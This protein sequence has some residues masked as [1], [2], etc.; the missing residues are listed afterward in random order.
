MATKKK[1][2]GRGKGKP[3]PKGVGGGGKGR[4]KI[5]EDIKQAFKE[6]SWG[7]I[8]ALTDVLYDDEQ[9][10]STRVAAAEVILNRAWGRPTQPVEGAGLDAL[11]ALAAALVAPVVDGKG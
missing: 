4:P 5:P 1:G 7:A 2:P 9:P 6:L 10:G 11:A 3:F 8:D